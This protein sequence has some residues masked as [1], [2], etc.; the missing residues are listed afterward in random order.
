MNTLLTTTI[1]SRA[2]VVLAMAL[3]TPGLL[4]G[5][6]MTTSAH[7]G[8]V[9]YV[10]FIS[11]DPYA[12]R[13]GQA[14]GVQGHGF[15]PGEAVQLLE[16][17]TYLAHTNAGSDGTFRIRAAYTVPY[18]AH[19]GY[20]RLTVTGE[21]SQHAAWQRLYV[22]ALQPWA[23]AS[24]Y[25]VHTG[26]RVRFSVN[27]FAAHEAIDVYLGR[28]SLGH[29]KGT[30]DTAGH[31]AQVGPFRVDGGTSAPTYTFVG[32]RSGARVH[33]TLTWLPK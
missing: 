13:P 1:H 25:V 32:A 28:T 5:L 24:T 26:D 30:T 14:V 19:P 8:A 10:P 22:M 21:Q 16:G 6:L 9:T 17:Q 7:V 29:S 20:V 27:D 11:L 18:R 2:R 33:V 12:A 23:T 4:A 31:L 3:L 15:V